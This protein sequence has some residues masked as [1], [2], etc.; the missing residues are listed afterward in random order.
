MMKRIIA[1][2][3]CL[4]SVVLFALPSSAIAADAAAGAKI[5]KAN[6]AAC[7]VGGKNKINP[8]KTLSQADLEKYG[9]F[10][11][12]GIV[13]QVTKGAGA[14]P[15]FGRKL[16]PEQIENVAAYVLEQAEAGW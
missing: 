16:K 2:F 3:V 1:A 6:C 13:M 9:K 7:H 8:Q 14:M 5:F 11:Q 10:S 4:I 12:E 15:A